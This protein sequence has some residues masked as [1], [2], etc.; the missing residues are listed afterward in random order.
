M[1]TL[2]ELKEHKKYVPY[3]DFVAIDLQRLDHDIGPHQVKISEWLEETFDEPITQLLAFRGAAKSYISTLLAPWLLTINPQLTFQIFSQS[4]SVVIDSM[5]QIQETIAQHPLCYDLAMSLGLT[6]NY[7]YTTDR[8]RKYQKSIWNRN[9][10]RLPNK[11]G[12]GFSMRIKTIT[13][14]I[15]GGRC[16][17]LIADDIE[18]EEN[19]SEKQIYKLKTVIDAQIN[20]ISKSRIRYNGTPWSEKSLYKDIEKEGYPTLRINLTP[21]VW[22]AEF[23]PSRYNRLKKRTA[24]YLWRSQYQLEF[25]SAPVDGGF[26][27]GHLISYNSMPYKEIGKWKI[28]HK[29]IID[30]AAFWDVATGHLDRSVLSLVYM[31][32]LNNYY[33]QNVTILPST[34]I[35]DGMKEQYRSIVRNLHIYGIKNICVEEFGPTQ[36]SSELERTSLEMNRPLNAIPRYRR[37]NKNKFIT[38]RL[39]APLYNNQLFV[40]TS[41]DRDLLDYEFKNWRDGH[42]DQVDSIAGC[43]EELQNPLGHTRTYNL[44]DDSPGHTK[45]IRKNELNW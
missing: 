23:P 45:I 30:S 25:V 13:G 29:E 39:E 27:P 4:Q 36:Y 11:I 16:D 5:N 8:N 43:I 28:D 19:S 44:N 34:S 26:D 10:I 40:H 17:I 38:D 12:R 41:V 7:N 20:A 24:N 42:D 6:S 14:T 21:D 33:I 35:K 32:I 2:K 37:E 18:S 15:T 31:D 3:V 9:E 22:P 1:I